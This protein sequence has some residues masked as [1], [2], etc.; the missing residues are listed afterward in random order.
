MLPALTLALAGADGCIKNNRRKV[1]EKGILVRIAATLVQTGTG[2]R[3]KLVPESQI[4]DRPTEDA[5][6]GRAPFDICN[7]RFA[8]LASTSAASSI[9][10]PN[11]LRRYARQ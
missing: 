11:A 5:W 9:P 6:P 10:Q 1:S 2:T 8:I 7:L 4:A 3:Q